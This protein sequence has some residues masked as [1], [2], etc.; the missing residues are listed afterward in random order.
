VPLEKGDAVVVSRAKK[1]LRLIRGASR[2]YFEI[3]REKLKWGE[4]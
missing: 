2:T 1:S 4:P 3:L